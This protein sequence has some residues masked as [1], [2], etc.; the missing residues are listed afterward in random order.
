MANS[1]LSQILSAAA[2]VVDGN[3]AK[4]TAMYQ[5]LKNTASFTGHTKVYT[6][7]K[8]DGTNLPSDNK[9]VAKS[10]FEILRTT[11]KCSSEI[12]NHKLHW[13]SGNSVA[14]ANVSWKGQV[15]LENAPVGFL[16]AFEKHLDKIG[17]I[18][19]DLPTYDP[20]KKW[21]WDAASERWT[22]D[23]VKSNR[24]VPRNTWIAVPDSG[25]PD[26]GVPNEVREVSQL[27]LE[28]S[29][30]KIELSASLS[31]VQKTQLLDNIASLKIAVKSAR[32]EA[33]AKDIPATADL[34]SLMTKVLSM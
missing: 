2:V 4:L 21:N 10:V 25:N 3:Y 29:W 27:V 33:N 17:T 28:G 8:E 15:V 30:E 31:P 6:P 7:A 20:E 1:R 11:T 13:E 12:L 24:E 5:G 9:N 22:S 14:K 34:T 16:L 26:K 18:V 23:P 19:G 32:E